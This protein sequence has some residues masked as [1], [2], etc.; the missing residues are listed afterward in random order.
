MN[1]N[2]IKFEPIY[3]IAALIGNQLLSILGTLVIWVLL[4]GLI[5]CPVWFPAVIDLLLKK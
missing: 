3:Q 4:F 2:A 1:R 5:S